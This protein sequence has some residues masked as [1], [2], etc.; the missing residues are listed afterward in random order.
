MDIWILT[1]TESSCQGGY[2]E[3]LGAFSSEALAQQAAKND[4]LCRYTEHQN[5]QA[6]WAEQEGC[7]YFG[8]GHPAEY[9]WRPYELDS[10]Y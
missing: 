1:H 5:A 3:T 6:V 4:A 7:I 10:K 9:R 8:C 2:T